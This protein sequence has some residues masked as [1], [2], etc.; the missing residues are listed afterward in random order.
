MQRGAP[1]PGGHVH[2]LEEAR[3]GEGLP[4]S[5]GEV[6]GD[7]GCEGRNSAAW[8]HA[9]VRRLGENGEERQAL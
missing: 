8:G 2:V 1:E 9:R 6:V 7:S 3:C 5:A 4:E